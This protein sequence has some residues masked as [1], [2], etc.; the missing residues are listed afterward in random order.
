MSAYFISIV[1]FPLNHHYL[2]FVFLLIK[3]IQTIT[4]VTSTNMQNKPYRRGWRGVGG[5]GSVRP[6]ESCESDNSRYMQE[7][8]SIFGALSHVRLCAHR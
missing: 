8:F 2:H 1:I 5:Y 6:D 7:S 4:P 3:Y